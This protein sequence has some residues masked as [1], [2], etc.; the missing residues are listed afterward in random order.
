MDTAIIVAII[1]AAATVAAA[2]IA[3]W[4][5]QRDTRSESNEQHGVLAAMIRDLLVDTDLIHNDVIDV[6][7]SLQ[8]HIQSHNSPEATKPVKKQGTRVKK[9]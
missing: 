2:L 7:D 9:A 1:G 8:A 4:K 5:E 3:L 6:R